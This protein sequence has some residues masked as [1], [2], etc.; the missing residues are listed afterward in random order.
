M[1]QKL[2]YKKDQ[3]GFTLIELM[4]VIAII[5]ILAA[6]AIP[7]FAAY[8]TRAKR[9]KA[10]TLLGVLRSAQGALQLDLSCYGIT[11]DEPDLDN[12]TQ[13]NSAAGTDLDAFALSAIPASVSGGTAAHAA[14]VAATD[15]N[16]TDSA[17]GFSVP[18]GVLCRADASATENAQSYL[19]AAYSVGTDRIF[20]VDG[21]VAE[22]IYFEADNAWVT[23]TH[24]QDTWPTGNT[25]PATNADGTNELA[26][27]AI[28][29]K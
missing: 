5:G 25:V 11:V 1:L 3:K 4:I 21:D 18:E 19:A 17:I 14:A 9:T 8:R 20:A 23:E 16:P 12:A 6:I 28:A 10:S 29:S 15:S 22:T 24:T 7:Q 26:G 13:G 27:W 2:Q